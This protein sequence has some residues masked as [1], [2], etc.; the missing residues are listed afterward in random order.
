MP[1]PLNI[2]FFTYANRVSGALRNIGDRVIYLGIKNIFQETLGVFN[3]VEFDIDTQY[4]KSAYEKLDAVVF[5]GTP[6]LAVGATLNLQRRMGEVFSFFTGPVLNM[7]AGAFH[8]NNQSIDDFVKDVTSSTIVDFF[9]NYKKFNLVTVRDSS[10]KCL[11]DEL[12][13]KS[14][15]LPCPGFYS[16]YGQ[17]CNPN[18]FGLISV[19][20]P[21]STYWD[22]FEGNIFSLYEELRDRYPD[23]VF[24]AHDQS[25]IELLEYLGEDYYFT[26]REESFI[27]LLKESSQLITMRIHSALPAITLGSEV[28]LLG[29][30]N[31]IY[32][33]EQHSFDYLP[34]DLMKGFNLESIQL[35]NQGVSSEKFKRINV[36]EAGMKSYKQ[37]IFDCF[38]DVSAHK[39]LILSN[40]RTRGSIPEGYF[41]TADAEFYIPLEQ[42]K[43][44]FDFNIVDEKFITYSGR[45][46][47]SVYGPYARL[48]V[49]SYLV[50]YG[51]FFNGLSENRNFTFEVA[52]TSGRIIQSFKL[53]LGNGAVE[54][55]KNFFNTFE[56]PKLEFR[57]KSSDGRR[58][59]G[60]SLKINYIRVIRQ[61]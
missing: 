15:L 46:G 52:T 7:G 36:L 49:G 2:G 38:S 23:F 32:M 54:I 33:P 58:D 45:Y 30:D 25:D 41:L 39:K 35:V 6:Q 56:T 40:S 59:D 21:T 10:A 53:E 12:S 3:A 1:T 5:C 51:L 20:G 42:M 61:E 18:G 26:D 47:I 22:K 8:F 19:L 27:K 57:I 37:L 24:V 9:I 13:V 14:H 43:S 28:V 31:R 16:A 60:V 48:P 50:K 34:I 55:E 44:S 11:L 17:E 4:E 29:F